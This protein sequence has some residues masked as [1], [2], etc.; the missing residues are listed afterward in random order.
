MPRPAIPGS[1]LARHLPPSGIREF[2]DLV[3]SR[4][5]VISLGVGEPDF[6]TPWK[7]C[8]TAVEGLRRGRTS[9]T[10]NSGLLELREA[11]ARDLARRYQVEYDPATEILLT[12]GVSEGMDLVMRAL[13]NPGDEV[14]VPEPCY[15]AYKPCVILAGGQ[16]VV[17]ETRMEDGFVPQLEAVAAAL[18]PR[19]RALL[20][21]YPNNPTGAVMSRQ[22]LLLLAELAEE[23]NLMLIS[24]EIYAHLTYTGEHTCVS[25]LPGSRDRTVLLNGFS[26]AYAMTGWRLGYA[27]GPPEIIEA[28]TRIHSYTALC[29]PVLAQIAAREALDN[30]EE[31]MQHMVS[32]YNQRRRLLLQGYRDLG[33]PCFE[34]GGAFYTFPS[35]AH[36]GLSSEQFARGLL[37]E[38]NVAAVPGTAFGACGEG[39]IRCTYAAQIDLLKE[40]LRRIGS[41]LEKLAAG[42]ITIK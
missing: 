24:D 42:Q 17:L 20:I 1:E 8:D 29:A 26:K 7:I 34:P 2:F 21:S 3:Q 11:I 10:S 38:E 41:F 15:V 9:Y 22:Q 40:A 18:T 31:E 28:M 16:P 35:I 27:C 25:S 23:H 36:T 39:F 30:C 37:F 12:N 19:T 13:L 14:L 32:R 6:A 4:E 33:I 5:G